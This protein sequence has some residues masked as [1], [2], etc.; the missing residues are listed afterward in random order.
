MVQ[1]FGVPYFGKVGETERHRDLAVGVYDNE[2][3]RVVE[4]VNST[5]SA[6]QFKR[7]QLLVRGVDGQV[8]ALAVE[9]LASSTYT[10]LVPGEVVA[11]EAEAVGTGN[12]TLTSFTLKHAPVVAGTLALKVN[13]VETTTGFTLDAHRGVI[14]F[15]AAV[16]NTHAVVADYSYTSAADEEDVAIPFLAG[17]IP[18]VAEVDVTVPKKVGGTN[19]TATLNVLVK[20]EVAKDMLFVGSTAWGDLD[21]AVA[22]KLENW[23]ALAGLIPADVVR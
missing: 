3:R 19:G 18:L 14:T 21:A 23:L 6:K 20:A 9:D 17:C 7:G 13:N 16:P 10:L 8:S 11:V 22:S 2:V 5:A 1:R 12:G 15:D 4:L